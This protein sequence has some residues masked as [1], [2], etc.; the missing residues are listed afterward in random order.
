MI[1]VSQL[2][3]NPGVNEAQAN[4]GAGLLLKLSEDKLGSREAAQQELIL[5]VIEVKRRK[6][7]FGCSRIAAEASY[8][9]RKG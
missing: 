9:W 1:L 2:V 4:G 8:E 7:R 6:P 3:A 5:A